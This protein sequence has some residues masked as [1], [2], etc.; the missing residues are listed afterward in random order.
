[1]LHIPRRLMVPCGQVACDQEEEDQLRE[2][3]ISAD[4]DLAARVAEQ[5]Q[6]SYPAI[7]V[8][9]RTAEWY[10]HEILRELLY[11]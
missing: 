11:A 1:M 3:D 9:G 7:H 4:K 10:I 2:L 6:V 8:V 5:A